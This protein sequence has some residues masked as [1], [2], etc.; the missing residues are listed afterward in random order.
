MPIG[1]Q[2]EAEALLDLASM[3]Q[4]VIQAFAQACDLIVPNAGRDIGGLE[5]LVVGH[6][7]CEACQP[8]AI[9]Q[10]EPQRIPP[11]VQFV[12]QC[13]ELTGPGSLEHLRETVGN[14]RKM[15]QFGCENAFLSAQ[16]EQP[17]HLVEARFQASVSTGSI[18]AV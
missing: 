1:S 8:C 13:Q 3:R 14:A 9:Q 11:L 6:G 4:K 17:T 2:T 15:T 5:L 10:G 16:D 12:Q 18:G 7:R